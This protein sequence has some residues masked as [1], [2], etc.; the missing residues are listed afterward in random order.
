[1]IDLVM[2]MQYGD[3][4]K[5]TFTRY[6]GKQ[7]VYDAFVRTCGANSG[8]SAVIKDKRYEFHMLP[9]CCDYEKP[10]IIPSGGVIDVDCF[11]L[12]LE[13]LEEVEIKPVVWIS[14]M[15]AISRVMGSREGV[16]KE[17]VGTTGMGVGTARASKIRRRSK[18][19]RDVPSLEPYINDKAID[20]LF[21][22]N[23]A[24]LLVET[25]QGFGL[26]I[27]SKCYPY[28]TSTNI[29]P[30]AELDKLGLS[31]YRHHKVHV[32]GAC[33]P[34]PTRIAGNSGSLYKETTWKKLGLPEQLTNLEYHKGERV[35]SIARVGEWDDELMEKAMVC[36][37]PDE[38][39]LSYATFLQPDLIRCD[40][41]VPYGVLNEQVHLLIMKY[42]QIKYL[43]VDVEKVLRI[44][45]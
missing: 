25:G 36:L 40:N 13:A 32:Y 5:G 30:F 37:H 4:G 26:S 38:I 31:L 42:P 41:L 7:G 6:L 8:H 2:G 17:K 45:R 27:D 12:E 11:F 14:G 35:R 28:C 29:S 24:R 34:Y 15:A 23:W 39:C 9:V 21:S 43:G 18:L 3:E 16:Y 10:C 33:K 20:F 22:R 44:E 19:A 1:M